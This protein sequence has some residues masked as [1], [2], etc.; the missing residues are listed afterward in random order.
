MREFARMLA[1][2]SGSTIAQYA[3][4]TAVLSVAMI[5]ALATIAAECSTQLGS[6]SNG[7]TGLETSPP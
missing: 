6:T 2:G 7:L 1:D 3:V 4:I 5:G